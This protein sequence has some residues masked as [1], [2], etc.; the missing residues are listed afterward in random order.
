[1]LLQIRG[2]EGAGRL[3]VRELKIIESSLYV[4]ILFTGDSP[5]RSRKECTGIRIAVWK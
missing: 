3:Q 4:I 1:M 5:K 2:R